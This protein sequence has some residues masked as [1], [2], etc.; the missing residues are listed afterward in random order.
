MIDLGSSRLDSGREGLSREASTSGQVLSFSSS[1]EGTHGQSSIS[2]A[3]AA[4]QDESTFSCLQV[5]T[6]KVCALWTACYE[7]VSPSITA[8]SN[9]VSNL[10]TGANPA[11]D[12]VVSRSETVKEESALQRA[13]SAILIQIET[14]VEFVRSN[15]L[16]DP[17][18][19]H[20]PVAETSKADLSAP[21]ADLSAPE[22]DLSA[23]EV[24]LS[25][26]VVVDLSAPA[27]VDLSK[28]A[29]EG[30]QKD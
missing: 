20:V 5:I 28:A 24:G 3:S 30:E 25:A 22:A 12:E 6:E 16:A 17:V 27:V 29:A 14:L 1:R 13:Y 4:E 19:S 11:S 21:E 10:F 2:K 26:P 9:W 7:A 18:V 15:C 23:P 8:F